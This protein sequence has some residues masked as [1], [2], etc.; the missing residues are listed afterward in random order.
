M[1]YLYILII[2]FFSYGF[3][4][5]QGNSDFETGNTVLIK[6][7]GELL[8]GK[9]IGLIT[10]KTGVDKNGVHIS[11]LLIENGI[12]VAKIFTPEHGFTADDKYNLSHKEI[13]V[14]SLY[15]GDYSFKEKDVGD[16]DVLVFDIQD[17]GVRFYTYTSTL[18]LTMLDAKKIG[19]TYI[20]CDRPSVAD[21]NYA[22]GFMLDSKFESFVGKIPVP[23]IYGLTIGE[24][25]N[26]LNSYYVKNDDF[27]VVKMN[28]YTRKT[29]FGEV[30][31]FWIN[32][33]PSINSVESARLYPSLCFLE[34]TNISE[35]RGTIT[36]F[37]VFGAPFVDAD[38]LLADLNAYNLPGL[39]FTV[40]EFI[41]S[42]DLLPSY[43]PMKYAGMTCP[44]I[45]VEI[46]DL[47]AYRPFETS[48]AVLIAL[49]KNSPEFRWINKNF[50]DKLA[51]TDVLRKMID[52]GNSPE[53]IVNFN[54]SDLDIF[55]QRAELCKLYN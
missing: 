25:A 12:N 11:E 22:G 1:K 17:L 34:G 36:H 27:Y 21:I 50:I 35:G 29:K 7:Y 33:S 49:K 14:I 3:A 54:K 42:Q 5:S 28:N 26:Y 55:M 24:L 8:E 46:T 47:Y 15:S 51:G 32:P 44:G 48:V 19:K 43:K 39:N 40:T 53:E 41:P 16:V 18:Y 13:P 31:N 23:V 37:Q 2:L 9:R 30:L 6:D 10:N 52:D 20:V 45:S 38:K 4:H